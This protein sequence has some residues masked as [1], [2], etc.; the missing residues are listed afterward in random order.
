MQAESLPAV[1]V[2]NVSYRYGER[3]ALRDLSLQIPEGT[4]WGLLGPN[5]GGKSTFFRLLAT[6]LPVQTGS[7]RIGGQDLATQPNAVRRLIGI[8]FQSPSLDRKLTVREN[9]THQGHLYGLSGAGLRARIADTLSALGVADRAD[10]RVEKLSGGLQRRAEIAKSLLHQPRFLLLDEPST[11]LDPGARIELW[12]YLRQLHEQRNFTILVSTHL[13]DEA[14]SCDQLAILHE[15]RLVA[16]GTPAQLR[17]KVGGDC[18]IIRGRDLFALEQQIQQKYGLACRN[19]GESLRLEIPEAAAWLPR[20][21]TDFG[22]ELSS[23]QWGR[24]TLEDVFIHLTGQRLW[25]AS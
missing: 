12:R 18:L 5:G 16:E 4:I 23:V 24:P 10:E 25:E 14:E 22:P 15:G 19:L 11:G 9:L 1:H 13:L 8:T 17:A 20:L 6:I 7:L 21:V 3:E 2:E